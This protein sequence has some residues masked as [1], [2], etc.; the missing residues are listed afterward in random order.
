MSGATTSKRQAQQQPMGP[1]PMLL[2][3]KEMDA[4]YETFCAIKKGLDELEIDY[5]VTGGSLLGAIRQHSI[6]F[7]DDDIDIA[8]IGEESYDRV[9]KE[10]PPLLGKSEYTYSVRPWEAGD[11]VRPKRMNSVFIDIF[12]LRSFDTIDD[13]RNLIGVKAN[14]QAQSESYVQGIV[15]TIVECSTKQGES[16]P[17]CPFWQF[18]T[19]KAIEMWPK[20]AYRENELFPLNHSL[21]MG[22]L[23]DVKG[24]RMPVV[25]LKRA[26]GL[27][28]F[29]V[30]YQSQSHKTQQQP[31]SIESISRSKSQQHQPNG[32]DL[33][34]LTLTG[35]AW[36]GGIKTELQ[37]EHYLPV[38]PTAR[39]KRRL[40][41]FGK[42]ELTAYLEHQTLQ[43]EE[44]MKFD[45]KD[46]GESRLE[47]PNRT[48]YMDGVF[49]LF[50]IGHLEAIRQCA[51]LGN[52]VILGV[53]GDADASSYKRPPIICESQRTQ[54]VAALQY[55]D[56][57]VCPCPLV[58][59]ESFM[60]EHGIGL[61]VHGTLL[62]AFRT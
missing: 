43:E 23:T 55:V 40:T 31:S 36:E 30:Y 49:D 13:L 42:E 16:T 21:K 3:R 11:R 19:R 12:T 24:P 38:M 9:I 53:T 60:R 54:L 52:K 37:E 57:V 6:L 8:I 7:C 62:L 44:W 48:V 10:L 35:G 2:S 61:V 28:C 1:E 33:K 50:H 18:N 46:L 27:D 34:P 59:T 41:N 26:F 20:E 29:H 39:A 14:G 45:G 5:I 4:L 56:E 22:P 15:D 17:L 51:E 25:L 47:R 58:V 32:S